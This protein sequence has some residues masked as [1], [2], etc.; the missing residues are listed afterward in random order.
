MQKDVEARIVAVA[1]ALPK[2]VA[3]PLPVACPVRD[4][5][6]ESVPPGLAEL[7]SAPNEEGVTVSVPEVDSVPLPEWAMVPLS[8]GEE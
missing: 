6:A 4:A 7:E 2:V 3:E 1:Y 5:R 8:V